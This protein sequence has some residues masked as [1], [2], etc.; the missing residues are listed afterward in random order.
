MINWYEKPRHWTPQEGYATGDVLLGLL[1]DGWQVDGLESAAIRS[2]APLYML[3]L[4]RNGE[5]QTLLVL[6]GPAVRRVLAM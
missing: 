5:V 4:R 6:D 2:R 1:A 3:T